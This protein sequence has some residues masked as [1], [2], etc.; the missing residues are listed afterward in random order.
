MSALTLAAVSALLIAGVFLVHFRAAA[1]L[2]PLI[3]IICIYEFILAIKTKRQGFITF[4]GILI[5]TILSITLILPALLP[6]MDFYIDRRSTPAETAEAVPSDAL[7]ENQYFA[8]YNIES[9]YAIGAKKWMIGLTLLG[10]LVGLFRKNRVVI[11][12]MVAWLLTLIGAG[13]LYRLNIP[14]LAFTNMTGM[15]VMLYLPIGVI[16]GVLV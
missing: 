2:L 14:L 15:M 7:E 1:F 13:L 6:A 12:I 11:I 8:N 4:L 5:I 9:L 10:V 16:V 3:A